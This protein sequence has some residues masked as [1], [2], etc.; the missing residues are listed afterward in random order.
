[1]FVGLSKAFPLCNSGLIHRTI[2]LL[3]I[4]LALALNTEARI[5]SP[6]LRRAS[7]P[8]SVATFNNYAAQSNTNCG[9]MAGRSHFSEPLSIGL[10]SF[11]SL[12]VQDL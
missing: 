8:Y 12:D 9:P 2:M 3:H 10:H 1:M 5:N 6:L 7:Y 4:L 11:C